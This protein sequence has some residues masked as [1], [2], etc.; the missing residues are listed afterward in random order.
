MRSVPGGGREKAKVFQ[1]PFEGRGVA[2]GKGERGDVEQR[3]LGMRQVG[4]KERPS[5]LNLGRRRRKGESLLLCVCRRS[6]TGE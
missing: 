4:G 5:T 1:G 2:K 3:D 6:S